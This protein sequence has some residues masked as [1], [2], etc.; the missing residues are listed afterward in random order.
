MAN[1]D[2][3][4]LGLGAM[5]AATCYQL[6]RRGL[7]VIGIDQFAPPH[8]LGSTHGETRITRQ[9]TG[10]GP[11]FVPLAMRSQR[12]WREI[13]AASGATLFDACGGLIVAPPQ[14]AN[15][16][17]GQP[18]FLGTTLALAQAFGIA[19]QRL[20]AAAIAARYP[21]LA[22][23]GDER[24]YFEPGAGVLHPE[25]C[26]AAQLRLAERY[27]ARL[28]TGQPAN[29]R[30]EGSSTVVECA[31][32]L[33]R[34]AKVVV[35]A[36]A[37]LPQLLPALAPR[38][39]VSRQVMFWFALDGTQAY[40][41]REF[42]VFI[43]HWGPGEHDVFYG[44]PRQGDAGEIKIAT[45]QTALATTADAID[46][47][48]SDAEASAMHGTHIAGRLRG[49]GAEC[50]RAAT[51]LYTRTPDANFIVDWLPESVDTLVVSACSGHGFKHSAAIGE[52]VADMVQSGRRPDVLRPFALPNRGA[53][54]S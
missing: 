16:L 6:A 38:L 23:R 37:W 7:R 20:D 50:R 48:V 1:P 53:S 39:T 27:G 30:R 10:E 9:A 34:A 13:E 42:P 5:G 52:A 54:T 18:D 51:C 33:H 44:M 25:A 2:V 49:I 29:L 35:A 21:Q 17:H 41:P 19:H 31:G 4:V 45:E 28:I 46:R 32:T 24:G 26:V 3:L 43:W 47:T 11:Q 12:L 14:G 15:R 36:G 8:A 22:L 40:G